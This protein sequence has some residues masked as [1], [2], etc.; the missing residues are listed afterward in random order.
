MQEHRLALPAG[1]RIDQFRIEC[2][3][4]K[5]GFGI[6][7]LATDEQLGKRVAIKELLPDSIATRIEGQTVVPQTAALEENWQ[8][9]KERFLEEARMLA[10]FSHPAILAVHR[11]IEA[12]GTAYIVMDYIDGES[13][14]ARM[15]RTG[16]EVDQAALMSIIGPILDGLDEV[17]QRGL[18][19]RDIKPE[20]ILID[21]RGKPVLIDF[22]SAREIVG[23]TV[24][25]TSIV[26]H[27]YSPI[28]QYQSSGKM[29]PWTDIYSLAAVMYRNMTGEKPPVAADRVLDDGFLPLSDM[30]PSDFS[31][32]FCRAVDWAL[33][34]KP[35]GRP[36][37]L[38]QWRRNLESTQRQKK[39]PSTKLPPPPER[40]PELGNFKAS[41]PSCTQRVEMPLKMSGTWINCPTCGKSFKAD[42][43]DQRGG[44]QKF[45]A[46]LKQPPKSNANKGKQGEDDTNL[47]KPQPVAPPKKSKLPVIVTAVCAGFL[48]LG[49]AV[50]MLRPSD[51][52]TLREKGRKLLQGEDTAKDA[53]K[54]ISLLEQAADKGDVEAQLLLG[55]T[56]SKDNE[57]GP[58]QDLAVS[59]K[60]F[61][62]A[63]E[64]Q[65]AEAQ[66]NL[67]LM[68]AIG[69]G[70]AK[71]EKVAVD[72][73]RKA[74]EQGLASAQFELGV[75]YADGLLGVAKDEKVAVDWYR[76]AAEQGFA[77]AQYNLG[78]MYVDGRGVAKDE[79]AAVEWYRK[80]AEEGLASAQLNLGLMHADG[81]GVAK[82]EKKA[83]ESYRKAAEQGL[84]LAQF[85]LG[86]M[87]ANGLG[88]AKDE[89]VAVEWIRKAAEQGLAT[90]QCSLGIMYLDGLGVAKDEK[91]A[92]EWFRKA[93]EQGNANSKARLALLTA[94]GEGVPQ[95][96][97]RAMAMIQQAIAEGAEDAKEQLAEITTWE[98]G[99]LTSLY[100]AAGWWSP[101]D[102]YVAVKNL[103]DALSRLSR[104]RQ[105]PA[106]TEFRNKIA[107]REA[108]IVETTGHIIGNSPVLLSAHISNRGTRDSAPS[109]ATPLDK[110]RNSISSAVSSS[111]HYHIRP[112]M[113]MFA[114]GTIQIVFVVERSGRV[115]KPRVVSNTSNE[116]FEI[117]T[118]EAVFAANVPAM[119]P[120]VQKEVG[121]RQIEMDLRFTIDPS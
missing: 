75:M 44:Y 24:A 77:A 73:C 108:E 68:Y 93:A 83:V 112:R 88:V 28:E 2:M 18:L 9:A 90:A 46:V 19:H 42:V 86:V 66:Y 113:D 109:A 85:E 74:A 87:Y 72:W 62:R 67:G 98:L 56:F 111:W 25:M 33:K 102:A 35:N 107:K 118:V 115:R 61:S 71:D 105:T 94:R 26:T 15:D 81:Q 54:G 92:A 104:M 84:A 117:V 29:G 40:A 114:S 64:Q 120:D 50:T 101:N 78:L 79:K 53:T 70:V 21:K 13:F 63:A 96:T 30:R 36:H 10:T 17:H 12:N 103:R 4:G 60:W 20:N 41:C 47:I 69:Q 121:T 82:D 119:P 39:A 100:D 51:P 34:V 8:W 80:A 89:K 57:G 65:N 116:T 5:G 7:Y 59:F 23:H 106:V 31:A 37:S 95:D 76:K 22:G 27:G 6:T 58:A 99:S 3:L 97:E 110:Y 32:E 49:F 52:D 48:V 45:I 43:H 38:D 91:M 14:Q 16:P 55:K 1:L 11:M